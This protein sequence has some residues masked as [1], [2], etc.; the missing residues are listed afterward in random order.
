MYNNLQPDMNL[1]PLKFQRDGVDGLTARFLALWKKNGRQ[2]PLVFKAPTVAARRMSQPFF[3]RGLNHLP[4][5][6]EDKAFVWITFSDDL[7]MQSRTSS[8]EYFENTLE[9]NLLTT[10]DINRGKLNRK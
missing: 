6:A 10:Q 5:W 1:N 8:G 9:N 3:V 4:Q 7:A 2:L